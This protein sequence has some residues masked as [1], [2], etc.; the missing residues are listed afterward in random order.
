MKPQ[1]HPQSRAEHFQGSP[2][3]RRK[4]QGWG[5]SHTPKLFRVASLFAAGSGNLAKNSVV[6]LV[7]AR[8]EEQFG[9]EATIGVI[10]AEAQPPQSVDPQRIARLVQECAFE[11][12]ADAIE[13]MY[14]SIAEVADQQAMAEWAEVA[15][16]LSNTPRR[17][18]VRTMLQPQQEPS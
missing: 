14:V 6:F 13:R 18:E 9:G 15:R 17:V 12:A 3:L 16:R 5:H 8:G 2:S 7:G 1:S 10:P 4:A 11:L